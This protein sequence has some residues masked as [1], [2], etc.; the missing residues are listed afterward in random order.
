MQAIIE[1]V[2]VSNIII[3]PVGVS[4]IEPVSVSNN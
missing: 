3:E 1:P 4:N 2:G